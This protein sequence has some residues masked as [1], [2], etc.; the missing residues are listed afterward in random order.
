[1]SYLQILVVLIASARLC[2]QVPKA[3]SQCQYCPTRSTIECTSSETKRERQRQNYSQELNWR[4]RES[5][6][7]VSR[8]FWRGDF[9]SADLD[10]ESFTTWPARAIVN[11]TWSTKQLR[12][13]IKCTH[14]W[15]QRGIQHSEQTYAMMTE[16]RSKAVD[17][18]GGENESRGKSR[19]DLSR[20]L[21]L[22]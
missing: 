19:G 14:D 11:T 1:M 4:S 9:V 6:I 2:S 12:C 7:V 15:G 20:L 18:N 13:C 8:K 3:V 17:G 16:S 10:L 21:Y 5:L 22:R